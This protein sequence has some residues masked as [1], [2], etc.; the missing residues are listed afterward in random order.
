MD[1]AKRDRELVAGFAAQ[2]P[3]L[4]EPEMMRVGRLA[5]AQ[6]AGLSGNVAKVHLVATARRRHRQRALVEGRLA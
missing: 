5:A 2:G 3:R 4:H 1:T 6:Q